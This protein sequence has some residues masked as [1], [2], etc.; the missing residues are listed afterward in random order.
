M[1]IQKFRHTWLNTDDNHK[2]FEEGWIGDE[3]LEFAKAYELESIRE[4]Y[5]YAKNCMS[6]DNLDVKRVLNG[7]CDINHIER[8][9]DE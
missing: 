8:I 9:T 1:D 5:E 7:Y 6:I 3:H 2:K 4:F